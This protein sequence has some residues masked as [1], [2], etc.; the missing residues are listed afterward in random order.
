MILPK[1]FILIPAYNEQETIKKI[2]TEVMDKYRNIIVINDGSCDNTYSQIPKND[3]VLII[4]QENKGKSCALINGFK[5]ALKLGGTAVVTIDGDRQ[6]RVCDIKKLIKAH[7][8]NQKF[9]ILATRYYNKNQ[10]PKTR[11][12]A[13]RFADFWISW[14]AN[15]KIIDSQSGFRLY[16]VAV[17]KHLLDTDYTNKGFVF[18]SESIIK[19]SIAGFPIGFVKIAY[20]YEKIMR[21]SHFKGYEDIKKI[22]KMVAK[23]IFKYRFSCG[24]LWTSLT[25]KVEI[26]E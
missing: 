12:F 1:I 25:A 3:N 8:N 13:N 11:L 2:V 7:Q 15:K 16:P 9:F 10:A 6:H 19:A 26:F 14:A 24:R 17:L 22:T 21:A 20:S 23:Y 18:E 5:M 4:N